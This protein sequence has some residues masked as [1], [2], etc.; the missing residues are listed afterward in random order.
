VSDGALRGIL[1]VGLAVVI[2]A[3]LLGSGL[4][5]STATVRV[6][7]GGVTD[8]TTTAPPD[9]AVPSG[10]V[11]VGDITVRVAN[12]TDVSG[13]A[14]AVTDELIALGYNPG[15][16]VDATNPDPTGLD[17]VYY[18]T[19]TRSFEA[20]AVQVAESLGLGPDAVLPL[21]DPPP[22]DVGLAGVLVVLGQNGT[23]AT[24][25][26]QTTPTSTTG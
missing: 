22:A 18:V 9:T 13:A 6:D 21:P 4:D 14:G 8:E 11:P 26:T 24:T 3:I 2:G 15:D 20:E 5:D 10:G 19:T 23:L 7:N 25:A 16:P 12:G 1:L 17:T